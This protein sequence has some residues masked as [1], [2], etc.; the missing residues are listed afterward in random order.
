M[1]DQ[2][3]SR[4]A[5]LRPYLVIAVIVTLMAGL[6][7][8]YI[9]RR[10]AEHR[11]MFEYEVANFE[12]FMEEQRSA[13]ALRVK[14]TVGFISAGMGAEIARKLRDTTFRS[15]YLLRLGRFPLSS[16]R[17]ITPYR[18]DPLLFSRVDTFEYQQ[19]L[20]KYEKY[21]GIIFTWTKNQFT[22]LFPDLPM[23]SVVMAQSMPV[24]SGDEGRA[25][26]YA[27]IDIEGLVQ[28]SAKK[29]QKGAL[30]SVRFDSP[31]FWYRTHYP[32]Q[33]HWMDF[34]YTPAE[35]TFPVLFGRGSAFTVTLRERTDQLS[36]LFVMVFGLGTL[37]MVSFVLVLSYQRMQ[38]IA[39]LKLRHALSEAKQ[40]NHAK[41]LFLANMSHEIR[42]P[43]NGVLGMAELLARSELP[44]GQRHYVEQIK[45]SG[46]TLLTVLN[47]ILDISKLES[48]QIAID[49]I[50]TD[51][52]SLV[53]EATAFF[54][55]NAHQKGL[56]ILLDLD[57]RLPVEVN[58]D[59]VR[60]RQIISNFISN[61]VKFTEVGSIIVTATMKSVDP[62]TKSATITCSVRDTGIG[63]S[64]QNAAA[65]FSRF[66]QAETE[67]TRLYGGTGLGLAICKEICELMGGTIGVESRKG[68]GSNFWF[69][70]P[71]RYF[72]LPEQPSVPPV[73][74]AVF[75]GSAQLL[76]V[77]ERA[78]EHRGICVVAYGTGMEDARAAIA[79]HAKNP[80]DMAILDEG[81][82]MAQPRLLRDTLKDHPETTALPC[83]I[84]GR[85]EIDDAYKDFD[86]V[87]TVPFDGAVLIDRLLA[88]LGLG[89]RVS[90]SAGD[91]GASTGASNT[92]SARYDG[93]NA[94]LA[95][96]NNL[97]V[98]FGSEVLRQLGFR[99]T[100]VS[101][102]KEALDAARAERFDVIFMDCQMPV[103]D[104]YDASR[105]LR[106]LIREG[107]IEPVPIV[108]VT[109]NAL[110]GD[111][112]RCLE[113]GMDY[114]ITKPMKVQ[115]LESVLR[116]LFRAPATL[117]PF[118]RAQR[119]GRQQAAAPSPAGPPHD[120]PQAKDAESP[121]MPNRQPAPHIDITA[122]LRGV[123]HLDAETFKETWDSM[124]NF[125][126]LLS[127]FRKDTEK[128]LD[129]IRHAIDM[130]RDG[131]AGIPAHMVKGS[132][133]ILGAAA[134]AQLAELMEDRARLDP[135]N[136][137]ELIEIHKHMKQVFAATL[138]E[139]ETAYRADQD[140]LAVG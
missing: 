52:R 129:A 125:E 130:E 49:P 72:A 98:L 37:G 89:P 94:L 33:T 22:A 62:A 133:R 67:M 116:N 11:Q 139:M 66:T 68:E 69:S 8:W 20:Q 38:R 124:P 81:P 101:N 100:T 28:D 90:G 128:Y 83:A 35:A 6:M 63:I 42:T 60:V 95:D 65:L 46:S 84:L 85:Q 99:V 1:T 87:V 127:L 27:A 14:D 12:R 134:L 115:D 30:K 15:P 91:R 75:S 36:S 77:V 135:P 55:P 70:L 58:V 43:L 86:L 117:L 25:V 19:L 104:G 105:Q 108:A 112:E 47:D 51:L 23:H 92:W 93:R 103:M 113:A 21:P 41:S 122:V 110:K 10:T 4:P 78:A 109:A 121:T 80:F 59:P 79:A 137:A 97:N 136:T 73:R 106:R 29:L 17:N 13:L 56:E 57:P 9:D 114:F 34:L 76:A 140:R 32:V 64:E 26:V 45:S 111:K 119:A 3:K 40:A 107:V 96:D 88:H 5:I 18:G 16:P 61:A 138:E 53:S 54:A 82:H 132:C 131:E 102:G 31:G 24:S 126:I 120:N 123:P 71:V 2:A 74:L 44:K 48:G 39:G 118:N 50:R 7:V